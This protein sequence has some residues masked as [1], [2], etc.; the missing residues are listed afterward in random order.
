VISHEHGLYENAYNA[1]FNLSDISFQHDRYD[2]AL[3]Y[4]EEA[5]ALARR[6][7]SR[8][9]EWGVTSETTY[10]L[11]MLGQWDEAL[12]RSQEVPEERLLDALTLSLL[13]GV[14][15][16][17]VHRG[18]L[19]EARR[20]LS[21]YEPFRDSRDLQNRSCFLA[22]S[23]CVARAEGR[24]DDAVRDG[25]EAVRIARES[26]HE[27][28]QVLKQG[29][30]ET[31]EAALALGDT[32][33][34]EELV[35]SIEVVPPGL[36]SGYLDAQAMRFRGRLV[37]A[38]DVAAEQSAAAAARFREVR[39]PFWLAVSLLEHGE[40]TDD[41]ASRAEAREIFESLGATPWLERLS[42]AAGS[43]RSVVPA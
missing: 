26:G 36:R 20:L 10:P 32:A 42:A 41:E 2:D 19:A 3:G 21:H 6:R 17:R 28:S 15:E 11:F 33:R 14:L 30:V 27:A 5:L 13:S 40:L 24:L 37:R 4:L 16:I 43:D 7:G 34:A 23:A 22:A 9:G 35:A 1:L 8:S 25:T 38:P 29:L 31:I 18:E 39:I 12:K